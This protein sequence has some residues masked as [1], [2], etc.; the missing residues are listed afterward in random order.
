MTDALQAARAYLERGW[1]E[2]TIPPECR[3][4]VGAATPRLFFDAMK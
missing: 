4:G 3:D 1:R 2:R